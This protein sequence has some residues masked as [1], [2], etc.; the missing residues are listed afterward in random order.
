MIKKSY[1][2]CLKFSHM[3]E[4]KDNQEKKEKKR[5]HEELSEDQENPVSRMKKYKEEST[6]DLLEYA[7]YYLSFIIT[8]LI[9]SL[10]FVFMEIDVNRFNR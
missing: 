3:L 8:I 10:I 5:D 9:C 2:S 6:L 1:D 4:D 7:K